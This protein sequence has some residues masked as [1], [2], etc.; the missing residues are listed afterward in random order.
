MIIN[1]E[2]GMHPIE[3]LLVEE[4]APVHVESARAD[5]HGA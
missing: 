3:M 1:D 5:G 2:E 4:M